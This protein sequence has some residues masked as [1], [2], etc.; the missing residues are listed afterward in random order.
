MRMSAGPTPP[1]APDT[2]S[3]VVG[4]GAQSTEAAAIRSAVATAVPDGASILPS[5]WVST[6]SAVSN[7]GAA[8]S[9]NR[10]ISTAPMAKLGATKQLLVLKTSRNAARSSSPRPL[11]P[12]TACTPAAASTG[13]V[14]RLASATVKSTT[15]STPGPA[16]SKSSTLAAT[17]T[18][19]TSEPGAD[20]SAAAT[21]VRPSASWTA[22]ATARPMRPATP[23]TPTRIGPESFVPM[24]PRLPVDV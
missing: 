24:G 16:S 10:I 4:S 3:R 18:P 6:I 7:H 21:S 17:V 23:S 8:N 20:G 15:T 5:W 14:A 12:T 13:S 1:R 9:A 2:T 11:V 22:S 19:L